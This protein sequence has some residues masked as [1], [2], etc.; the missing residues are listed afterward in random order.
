M[1]NHA[2]EFGNKA[3]NIIAK[4]LQGIAD[5]LPA[6]I[7]AGA[8]L[9][10]NFLNGISEQLP[11]ILDAAGNLILTFLEGIAN[12]IRKY[13]ARIRQAGLDIAWAIIDGVTFGLADKAWKI[14]ES[15]VNAA[16]NGYDKMKE[17]F[18]IHSP[19]R[20]MRQLAHYVGD[21]MILGLKD[22]EETI[23]DAGKSLGQGAYDAMKEPLDKINDMFEDDPAF[24]P[25]IAPVLNLEELTKQAQALG[26]IGGSLG[27]SAGLAN[28]ARP[29]VR[30]EDTKV[31][32]DQSPTQITF[33][34]NNYSPEALS[35]AEIYRQTH[36]QLARAR[37]LLNT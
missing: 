23:G 9:I 32:S 35:E 26:G 36:N 3:A 8:D 31:T 14:G 1:D 7:R 12:T 4:F 29:K 27:I 24:H 28:G 15:L 17:F 2:Y 34:Q 5:G 19:S 11:R 20:L 13:N 21:G 25:E 16:S 37:R 33:N 10:V 30:L 22:K 18:G 6:I